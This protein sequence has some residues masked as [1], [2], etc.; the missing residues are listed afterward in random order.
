MNSAL[1]KREIKSYLSIF[2]FI[3]IIFV[4]FQGNMSFATED[5][6]S[7]K[8]ACD[9]IQSRTT[10]E[11]CRTNKFTVGSVDSD[12]NAPITCDDVELQYNPYTSPDYYYDKTN[13]FCLAWSIGISVSYLVVSSVLNGVCSSPENAAAKAKDIAAK[14]EKLTKLKKVLD[15]LKMVLDVGGKIAIG[16]AV[17]AMTDPLIALQAEAGLDTIMLSVTAGLNFA[18]SPIGIPMGLTCLGSIVGVQAAAQGLIFGTTG[19]L[20]GDASRN[21]NKIKV[22]GDDWFSFAY[23]AN[24]MIDPENERYPQYG[25][26]SNSYSYKLNKCFTGD[27]TGTQCSDVT[28]G[29][30]ICNDTIGDEKENFSCDGVDIKYRNIKNRVYREK[31][32]KGK[33][34]KT[35]IE[36]NGGKCI[37]PRLD[38]VKGYKELN[39]RYYFKGKE[40]AQYAC[41][42]FIYRNN[43]CRL[44][45]GTL[46]TKSEAAADSEKDSQCK[47]AFEDAKNCCQ[48]RRAVGVCI[49]DK[50][51]NDRNSSTYCTAN[52]DGG[53]GDACS[54]SKD[55]SA[56]TD[57]TFVAYRSKEKSTNI[58]I[59]NYNS[60]PYSYNVAGGTEVKDLYCNGNYNDT[61]CEEYYQIWKKD[62][63]KYPTQ[64]Y[65]MTKN[66]CQYNAHCTEIADSDY[67]FADMSTN[68]FLPQVCSDFVG[69]SQNLPYPV[70][71]ADLSGTGGIGIMSPIIL[72]LGQYGVVKVDMTDSEIE[73]KV[74]SYSDA[75][76]EE[77]TWS[78]FALPS[79][80]ILL[81]KVFSSVPDYTSKGLEFFN[82]FEKNGKDW[83]ANLDNEAKKEALAR[84]REWLKELIKGLSIVH[85]ATSIKVEGVDF[86][87]GEY[88][89]FTAPMAQC[90]KETLNNMFY[91]KAG[92][93]KCADPSEKINKEGLCGN[94]T[95]GPPASIKLKKSDGGNRYIYMIGEDLPEDSNILFKIQNRIKLIIKLVAILALI[96][97]A[98]KFLMKGDLDI[99]EDTKKP[100]ALIVGILK[101]AIVFYFSVGD[102]WQGRFYNLVDGAMEYM[103]YKSFDLSMVGYIDYRVGQATQT[104]CTITKKNGLVTKVPVEKCK[105]AATET[106]QYNYTGAVQSFA[107]PSGVNAVKLEVY[108][109]QGGGSSGGKGGYSYGN[110]TVKEGNTLY[111]YVGGSGANATGGYNGGGSAYSGAYGGGGATDIR[112]GGTSVGDRK[113]VAGGGGGGVQ[114]SS[115]KGG[116]GGG[117]NSCGINGSSDFC[118]G[119]YGC[120]GSGGSGSINCANGT[121]NPGTVSNGGN[122]TTEAGYNS[123]GGGGGY[124]GGAS[125]AWAYS[126]GG[127]GGY[128]GGVTSGGGSSGINSG[129]GKA[130][131][132][133]DKPLSCETVFETIVKDDVQYNQEI[134]STTLLNNIK[135][136]NNEYCINQNGLD[137]CYNQCVTS[138]KLNDQGLPVYKYSEK[139]DGCYFG[140]NVYPVGKE[141]IGIFDSLDCKL[142]NYFAYGPEVSL[143]G[144]LHMILISML[145]SPLAIVIVVLGFIFFVIMLAFALKILYIFLMSF[146]AVNILIYLSP[147]IFPTLLFEKYKG[148]FNKWLDNFM[149]FCLQLI[150]VIIF[151]GFAIG[152]LD[153]LSIGSAKF[154][155][156]DQYTGRMPLMVCDGATDS[157]MCIFKVD[158]SKGTEPLFGQKVA[159]FLGLG[160]EVSVVTSITNDFS[161]TVMT[162][163]K[164]CL[165]MFVLL[166]FLD[167]MPSVAA[168]LTGGKALTGGTL[169]VMDTMKNVTDK[170]NTITRGAKFGLKKAAGGIASKF[171]KK[172]NSTESRKTPDTEK[173]EKK[174]E[175]KGVSVRD[176]SE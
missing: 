118:G 136:N 166:K 88:R 132:T 34:F 149:S 163:L 169:D 142:M 129:N 27:Y 123:G 4:F 135:N 170:T 145:F 97:I 133:Y 89:G 87:L 106:V 13:G 64:K 134:T 38:E 128:I 104:E 155:N 100:K 151:A 28:D 83:A 102:A 25:S 108:G 42:R 115:F 1:F 47:K 33:E 68:K 161:G 99:F 23:T 50:T 24:D 141:Y 131:I 52:S 125:G 147:L 30:G 39:Q 162:L 143:P 16:T 152:N 153:K 175:V 32:Y 157:V 15:A 79:A 54:F 18:K 67:E 53:Q 40:A 17:N 120:N 112:Y 3:C 66:F 91:N 92:T 7:Y 86:S 127:G 111:I 36:F 122:G 148:I 70:K 60:C 137:V 14:S 90:I 168:D 80:A 72:I 41:N 140:D 95:F 105:P 73:A 43:G 26:F 65:G 57:P 12:G 156:H 146:L 158:D 150:F 98:I 160:P 6:S 11:Q 107:V 49:Y 76:M 5:S 174:P 2:L 69:D 59:S 74:N 48:Q 84:S 45:D 114:D 19:G 21:I 61:T 124:G 101:F 35:P 119:K 55:I 176:K 31:I 172:D 44:S 81:S 8:S 117:G 51:K 167:K 29:D 10:L 171:K 75:K 154:I 130:I 58:C 46:I 173:V 113:L 121:A 78:L 85:S 56:G 159:K 116:G 103:Y 22:C 126:G 20:Y 139:Y 144:I 62:K 93:S 37:D 96:V 9:S 71:V 77:I 138:V 82:E 164:F 109:A 110:L 94:D 165:I 63:F